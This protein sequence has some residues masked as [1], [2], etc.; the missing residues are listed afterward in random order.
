[1]SKK[2]RKEIRFTNK[3]GVKRYFGI[4]LYIEFKEYAY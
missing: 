2:K 1:M 4:T 3:F